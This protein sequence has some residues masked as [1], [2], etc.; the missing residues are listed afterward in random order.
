[1]V[2]VKNLLQEWKTYDS[3]LLQSILKKPCTNVNSVVKV[4]LEVLM[5][6][7]I[8]GLAIRKMRRRM[9]QIKKGKGKSLMMMIDIVFY[10]VMWKLTVCL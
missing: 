1:M 9:N 8:E 10:N 2:L 3:M 6:V 5:L 4:F 7:T